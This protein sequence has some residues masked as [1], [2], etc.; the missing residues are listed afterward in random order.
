MCHL[1]RKWW[2]VAGLD[3][4]CLLTAIACG[5]GSG[6]GVPA[7]VTANVVATNHPL[8]ARY[9]ISV[10]Q[11]FTKAWVEFGTDNSYGRNTSD[12][13]P[14]DSAQESLNI[15]VAGMKPATLYHMRAHV[16]TSGGEW[17]DQ[18]QTFTTGSI[19]GVVFS[20]L[21]TD[22]SQLIIPKLVASRPTPNLQP[23]AGV[24]LYSLHAPPNP[25]TLRAVVTDLDGNIIWYYDVGSDNGALPIKP[26]PN[27]HFLINLLIGSSSKT[28]GYAVREID[29]AGTTIREVNLDQVNASLRSGN[30]PFS[31]TAFHHDVLAL[32]NRHWIILC[33]TNEDFTDLPGYP[34][35]STVVGDALVDVDENGR[36]VWAWRNFD[37]F[38]VH[39]HPFGLPDWTHG[40]GLA[41]SSTD[42]N[43]ILSFRN[44]NWV[45]KIDYRN[46]AGTGQVLWRLGE[47]GDF[48]LT[49]DDPTE[50]F[51]GQHY[52]ALISSNGSQSV[53]SV[54][55]NGNLRPI[56]GVPCLPIPPSTCYSRSVTIAIDEST[57]TANVNWQYASSYFSWWGGSNVLLANG[58][59]ELDLCAPYQ[60]ADGTSQVMEVTHD[61]TPQTVWQM[62]ISGANAYR[63]YRI[64]SLYPGVSWSQ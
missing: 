40:N 57:H 21:S 1:R 9:N 4:V 26:L 23:Q 47:E 31:V 39:R 51:Y 37:Y 33:S 58:N 62:T 10:G 19:P 8:V 44:Q 54:F 17:I 3:L 7:N 36:V 20:G 42:G 61:D 38:D 49:P 29:L 28:P 16:T 45:V 56:N 48:T 34:G 11:P 52:P 25:N 46:G 24:E 30:Y 55:D 6:S 32:P 12:V 14:S 15:L 5:G 60:L 41:Y 63:A 50:W 35:V 43:L 2:L 64:P 13:S 59:S 53:L 18:D 22:P 27:G